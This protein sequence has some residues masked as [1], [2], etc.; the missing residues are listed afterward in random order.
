[1]MRLQQSEA[2]IVKRKDDLQ[3][4]QQR[5]MN[6]QAELDREQSLSVRLCCCCDQMPMAGQ[7]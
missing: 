3:G 4:H 7:Q 2:L 1:M 5:S 6:L